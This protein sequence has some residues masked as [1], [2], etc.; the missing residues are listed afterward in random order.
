LINDDNTTITNTMM[1]LDKQVERLHEHADRIEQLRNPV[2]NERLCHTC[3]NRIEHGDILTDGRGNEYV[4]LVSQTGYA[5]L[6]KR[7]EDDRSED[8][9]S[10]RGV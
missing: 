2:D 3:D 5:E 4:V 1:D 8:R 10:W 9:L 7:V 6:R